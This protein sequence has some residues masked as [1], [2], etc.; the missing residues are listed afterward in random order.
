MAK[1]IYIFGHSERVNG[2]ADV[3]FQGIKHS[4]AFWETDD[5]MK[6]LGFQS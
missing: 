6:F 1:Y 5:P 4:F 3:I 2:L